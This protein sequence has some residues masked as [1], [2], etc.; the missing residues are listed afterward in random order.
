[1]Y[2]HHKLLDHIYIHTHIFL[3]F[4]ILSMCNH[5]SVL[6]RTLNVNTSEVFFSCRG[7]LC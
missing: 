6:V 7:I 4:P 1:M 3:V 5:Y 2:H